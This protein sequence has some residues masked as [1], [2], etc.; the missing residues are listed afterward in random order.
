ML[1]EPCAT[2]MPAV[3]LSVDACACAAVTEAPAP[4]PNPEHVAARIIK[5]ASMLQALRDYTSFRDFPLP[6]DALILDLGS[7][8]GICAYAF[9]TLFHCPAIGLEADLHHLQ[10]SVR[11]WWHLAAPRPPLC[12][13][14]GT[15]PDLSWPVHI[16][17]AQRGIPIAFAD[18]VFTGIFCFAGCHWMQ[19]PEL[20]ATF[21]RILKPQGWFGC[22]VPWLWT[23]A[24]AVQQLQQHFG[25][26]VP[27]P[28]HV[29][30][31]FA[32]AGFQTAIDPSIWTDESW[33][34]YNADLSRTN[35]SNDEIQAQ[36]SH[37]LGNGRFSFIGGIR[38]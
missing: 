24:H 8:S 37:L 14:Y 29:M 35:E 15:L 10:H 2:L 30:Q 1:P 9:D 36:L 26:T 11:Y 4:L 27:H 38:K 18:H 32:A 12:F 17:H 23:D 20:A 16:A 19:L 3:G 21:A 34:E 5:R 31:Q 7:G 33:G 28:D 22:V 25:S 6:P 13:I